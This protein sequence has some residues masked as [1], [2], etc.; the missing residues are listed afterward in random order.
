MK[1]QTTIMTAAFALLLATAVHA[2]I[3]LTDIGNT[4]PSPGTYDIFQLSTNG[5]D[6]TPRA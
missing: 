6:T 2:Q 5:T 3:T 4:A 1:S